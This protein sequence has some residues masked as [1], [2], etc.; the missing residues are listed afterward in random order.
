MT[1]AY[2]EAGEHEFEWTPIGLSTGVYI[3]T[4]RVNGFTQSKKLI[5]IK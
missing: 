1:D 5:L 4:L 3:C 2:Y